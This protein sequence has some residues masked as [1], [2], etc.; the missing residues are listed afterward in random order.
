M[1]SRLGTGDDFWHHLER[2]RAAPPWFSAA[3]LLS[4]LVDLQP[5][6]AA[7]GCNPT[8]GYST[9]DQPVH[10]HPA[11]GRPAPG[12]ISVAVYLTLARVLVRVQLRLDA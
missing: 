4:L 11:H 6:F 5:R 12:G 3:A 7:Y 9:H 2:V 8:Q 10:G 1:L